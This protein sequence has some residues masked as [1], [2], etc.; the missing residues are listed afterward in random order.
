MT[1]DEKM[2]ILHCVDVPADA[3][4]GVGVG[5]AFLG[6]DVTRYGILAR[7]PLRLQ[8]LKRDLQRALAMTEEVIAR[9]GENKGH[10]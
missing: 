7:T 10:G 6:E 8:W 3:G 4:G 1:E 2:V 5:I 9:R